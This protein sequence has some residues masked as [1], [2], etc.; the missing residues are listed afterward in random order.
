MLPGFLATF[1]DIKMV[2]WLVGSLRRSDLGTPRDFMDRWL[3]A[4]ADSDARAPFI[5]MAIQFREYERGGWL[6]WE[7]PFMV[8]GDRNLRLPVEAMTLLD[9]SGNITESP[10]VIF[11]G[12]VD[13]S[14]QG[15]VHWSH[16]VMWRTL[17]MLNCRN[18]ELVDETGKHGPRAK[19]LRRM[20]QPEIKYH[21]LKVQ[22]GRPRKL[23][24]GDDESGAAG[25]GKALH[26]C[27][28]HFRT[29]D[30]NSPGLFGRLHGR[31]WIPQHARGDEK[32]GE[33]K[34]DYQVEV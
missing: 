1:D 10:Y 27:R 32:L 33:V 3:A 25:A 34:K 2:G 22:V 9:E 29:Y 23:R 17:S 24:E 21:V 30:E 19:W 4:I 15:A 12:G 8:A 11:G 31:Y 6:I 7:R 20:K 16:T 18:V 14:L 5:E 28:G 26:V 13:E